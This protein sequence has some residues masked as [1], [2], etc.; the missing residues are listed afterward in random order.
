MEVRLLT[1]LHVI[2]VAVFKGLDPTSTNVSVVYIAYFLT[3][4]YIP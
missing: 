3:V 2:V 4:E 1:Q